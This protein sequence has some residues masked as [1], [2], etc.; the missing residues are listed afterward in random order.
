MCKTCE[1]IVLVILLICFGFFLANKINLTT[2]DLG[3][4]L[5][6]GEIVV[7][8]AF[9]DFSIVKKV[10]NTNFYSYTNS[11]FPF[12]NH[13]WGGGVILYLLFLLV[14]FNGL[15]LIYIF[16]SFII[17]FIFFKLAKSKSSL[18]IILLIGLL[19]IPLI[20][21][22]KEIR[23]EIFSYLFIALFFYVLW[24]VKNKEI[25][26]KWLIVLPIIQLFWINI[27]I[28]FVFGIFIIGAFLFEEL[29]LKKRFDKKLLY[30]FFS[31]TLIS[32]L[33]P[34]NISG[35]M[36]PFNIFKEYGYK[37][38]ENQSIF[39]L[40]RLDFNNPNILLFKISFILLFLSFLLVFL[41]NRKKFSIVLFIFSLVFGFMACFAIRNFTLFGLFAFLSICINLK[42]I[43]DKIKFKENVK[44][45]LIII[46]LLSIVLFGVFNNFDYFKREI[47][48]GLLG[49]NNN[50]AEFF[51][52]NDLKGPIFNN[53]DI[54]GYL[55]YHLY[56]EKV[57]VDNRPEAYPV[58]FFTEE[59]IPMQ[60]NDNVFINY[61][62]NAIFFYYHDFTPWAQEFLIRKVDDSNW[63][64]VFADSYSIIFLK[65]NELNKELI[66]KFEL[67]KEMFKVK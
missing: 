19:L 16:L 7:N 32:F 8:N 47:G 62:F 51:K 54:G 64:P 58:S 1:I 34:F 22:R 33:N 30:S 53:Y 17:F 41:L 12:I 3:R 14:G 46:S 27:H 66:H 25:S 37:I 49:G 4:H 39:F 23:P 61:D 15:S 26:F 9:S 20:S 24:K 60:E 13:H 43:L 44:E 6:N 36:Y 50:A 31:V 63:A 28:Y 38:V 57:F 40:H 65:R 10:L 56:P 55:I 18:F 5:K 35:L 2:A 59:Y 29:I 11:D 52:E 67:P 21:A 45:V 42:L 48:I